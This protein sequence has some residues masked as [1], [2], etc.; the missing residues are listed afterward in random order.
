MKP[1]TDVQIIDVD[2]LSTS[3][4]SAAQVL[5]GVIYTSGLVGRDPVDGRLSDTFE[6]QM[7][8][9]MANLQR[10]LTAA[11]GSLHTVIKT[12]VF[13]TRRED[14]AAM[15]ALYAT[16]FPEA[17]PARSTIITGLADPR[18]RFEIEA[19][20]YKRGEDTGKEEVR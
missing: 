18:L 17:K 13:L 5:R 19:I 8:A 10:V 7:Q 20:A 15:N 9:A 11:G 12:T 1:A 2:G 6:E 3:P 14:F 16:Y 4:L